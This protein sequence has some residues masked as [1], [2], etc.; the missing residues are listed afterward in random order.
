MVDLGR[1]YQKAT[2]ALKPASTS[3]LNHG[4]DLDAMYHS[5]R[6]RDQGL[7]HDMIDHDHQSRHGPIWSMGMVGRLM[8]ATML[9]TPC[10][11]LFGV[12][13]GQG[14]IAA[15]PDAEHTLIISEMIASGSRLWYHIIGAMGEDQRPFDTVERMSDFYHRNR[16][17]LVEAESAAEVAIVFSQDAVLDYGRERAQSRCNDPLHG[18]A[19]TLV[20]DRVPFDLLAVEDLAERMDRY[21]VLVLPNQACL[22]DDECEALR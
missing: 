18:A 5:G 12:Y 6:W 10:Y 1:P 19:E 17:Y 8:R 14:R 21:R 9:P 2:K 15:Q 7:I 20:R 22:S 4:G 16:E 13:G 3:V 11:H